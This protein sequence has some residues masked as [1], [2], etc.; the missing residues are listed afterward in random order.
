MEREAYNALINEGGIPTHSFELGLDIKNSGEYKLIFSYWQSQL[1]GSTYFLFVTQ[2]K[3]WRKFRKYQLDI[4]MHQMKLGKFSEHQ[5]KV[6]DRRRRCGFE[7]DVEL[8]QDRDQQSKLDNWMEYQD[9]ECQRSEKFQND[10]EQAQAQLEYSRKAL[11][12]AGV[13]GFEELHDSFASY[14]GLAVKHNS[15]EATAQRKMEFAEQHLRLV[16]KRLEVAYTLGETVERGA[17]IRCFLEAVELTR[18]QLENIQRCAEIAHR[19]LEPFDQWWQA[20]QIR[21]GKWGRKEPEEAGE[22]IELEAQS[23]EHKEKMK[24][25][26]ELEKKKYEASSQRFR[27]RKE[28]DFAEEGLKAARSDNFGETIERVALVGIIQ[29]ELELARTQLEESKAVT[30]KIELQGKVVGALGWV[31]S[32]KRK[33]ELHKILVEWIEQQRREIVSDC[34][35]FYED[36]GK[37]SSTGQA[38]NSKG[39]TSRK[40]SAIK[41]SGYNKTLEETGCKRD[42]QVART[43]LRPVDPSRVSKPTRK[44]STCRQKKSIS[45]DTSSPSEKASISPT[46]RSTRIS[47]LK[48]STPPPLR[49]IHSSRIFKPGSVSGGARARRTHANDTSS[50]AGRRRRKSEPADYISPA[51]S[52]IQA[53]K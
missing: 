31:S 18:M 38:K 12:A 23:S 21:W 10:F 8:H 40:R 28:V 47:R 20:K 50:S 34:V 42:P 15:E 37:T 3:K 22:R 13:L 24:I 29:K 41:A 1:N 35:K 46:R 49:P 9:Y 11:A 7:G 17:W 25:R 43:F 45:S 16:E 53:N 44:R 26:R 33:F 51:G 27:A 4:R 19:E 48:E 39:R 52:T 2:L 32:A 6:R 30:Q 14:Y 36:T 5:Q